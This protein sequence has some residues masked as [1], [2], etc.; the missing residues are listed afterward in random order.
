MSKLD[1]ATEQARCGEAAKAE[2][3]SWCFK[4]PGHESGVVGIEGSRT[5]RK[6]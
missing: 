5:R 4:Q 6:K 2:Y 1:P 3:V